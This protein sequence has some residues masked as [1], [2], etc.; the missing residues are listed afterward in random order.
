MKDNSNFSRNGRS[1]QNTSQIRGDPVSR[2]QPRL[3][4]HRRRSI[5]LKVILLHRPAAAYIRK[6]DR[7]LTIKTTCNNHVQV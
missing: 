5:Y 7:C 6:T 3:Q 1:W 4:H 2:P